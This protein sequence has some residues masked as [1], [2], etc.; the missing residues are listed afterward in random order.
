ME[1]IIKKYKRKGGKRER[2]GDRGTIVLIV[3]RI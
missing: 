2:D 1:I 3:I